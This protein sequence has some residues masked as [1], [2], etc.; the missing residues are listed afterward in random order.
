[1]LYLIVEI[2]VICLVGETS[3][4]RLVEII[5]LLLTHEKVYLLSELINKVKHYV[6]RIFL[7][8]LS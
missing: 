3:V 6:M 7:Y 5:L 1:M 8:S 2:S 4:G